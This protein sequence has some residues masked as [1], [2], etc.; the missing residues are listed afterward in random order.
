MK[1]CFF[2]LSF[3]LFCLRAG[4]QDFRVQIAA[5]ADSMRTSY[6]KEKGVSDFVVE[7]DQLGL[8]RYF[9]GT[10]KTRD[11]A[12][13]VKKQMVAKGFPFAYVID[14][15]EQRVLCGA[16]CPYFRNGMIFVKDTAQKKTVRTIYFESGRFSLSRESKDALDEMAAML[17][18]NPKFNLDVKGYTDAV[19]SAK[20]NVELASNRT[21]SARNYL[22]SKGIRADRMF[23]K[24][25]GEADPQVS[26]VDTEG[27]DAPEQRKVNRRVV[28][29]VTDQNGE[30][31]SS[32]K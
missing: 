18:A 13:Y 17:K 15:E 20:S 6:F 22:I 16:G 26:N 9:A 31:Q 8:Y 7:H 11:E 14:L 21:R 23:L 27:I 32:H 3:V 5:Y 2:A 24:V 4:A 30:V 25:F 19:G 29:T 12:E 10:F 28:L 1:R